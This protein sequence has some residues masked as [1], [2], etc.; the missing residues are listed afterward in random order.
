[1]IHKQS[2]NNVCHLC[3]REENLLGK[4][5][6]IPD[7]F[8][9][10]L[11]LYDEKHNL[12][13][14]S[15]LDLIEESTKIK[16]FSSGIYEKHILCKD[17]DEI[18]IGQLET[19]ASKVLFHGSKLNNP[20]RKNFRQPNGV[21]F[22]K[23][24]N[25]DYKKYKLFLLSILWRAAISSNPF[26]S[27]VSLSDELIEDIRL[28]IYNQDPGKFNDYPVITL[29]FLDDPEISREIIAQPIKSIN[30][31]DNKIT[32]IIGG[33]VLIF[34]LVRGCSQFA[35]KKL[36]IKENNS[37]VFLHIPKGQAKA[38]IFKYSGLL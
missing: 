11:N 1:M 9:R 33:L 34:Y 29:S 5:H 20:I 35:I 38:F 6:V 37:M 28:M 36:A 10:N 4:S 15:F 3:K 14:F 21:E 30:A 31:N 22:S 27:N 32:F 25:V 26:F 13:R 24:E 2:T 16:T 8:Y 23:I 19:Y 7:F 17:C 12:V 18:R